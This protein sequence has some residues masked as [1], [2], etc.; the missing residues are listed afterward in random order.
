[1]HRARRGQRGQSAAR[2]PLV[3]ARVPLEQ[4]YPGLEFRRRTRSWWARLLGQPAECAHLETDVHWMALLAPDRLYLRG[5]GRWV[6]EPARPEVSLCRE[7]LLR[8]TQPELAAHDGRI[9]AFEPDPGNFSQYFFVDAADFEA[10]GLI[11]EVAAAIERR[12]TAAR[13]TCA[14]CS[15]PARW[16]WFSRADVASLD[17]V[18]HIA[19]APG[20]RFCHSHGAEAFCAMLGRIP[21]ANL[22]YVNLPYGEAG[23]YLWI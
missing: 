15:L 20:T 3:M 5:K 12:L 10:A 17:D 2:H 19:A 11:P 23:A 21:E 22:L 18:G 13:E 14:E 1:M 16:L 8:V 4:A 7:C 6:R 9:V